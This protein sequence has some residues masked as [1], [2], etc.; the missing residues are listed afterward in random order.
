MKLV[1]KEMKL[2]TKLA[3][4]FLDL[5]VVS[6]NAVLEHLDEQMKLRELPIEAKAKKLLRQ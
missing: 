3:D 2:D 6:G 5:K 1:K 4:K